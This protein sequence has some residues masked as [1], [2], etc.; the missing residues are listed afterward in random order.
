VLGLR[1]RAG[2]GM[3]QLMPYVI[4]E[5]SCPLKGWCGLGGEGVAELHAPGQRA[6]SER[7]RPC[8]L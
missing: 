7:V 4:S 6:T 2:V 1:C 8:A 5:T 3:G